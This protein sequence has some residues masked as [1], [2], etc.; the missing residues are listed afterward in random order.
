[1]SAVFLD[2]SGWLSAL[3]PREA[4]HAAA[5]GAYRG[6]IQRGERLET[7]NLVL[8]EMQILVSR[9][10][11]AGEALRFLDAVYADPSHEV[12]HVTRELERAAIDRWLRRFADQR[13]SLADAT[14]FEV[15][16]E[17]RIQRVLTLDAH[18]ALA[19]FHAVP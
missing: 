4:Q 17:Q 6:G 2:T 1:V 3:S 11:D 8:A 7:T 15:M 12:V 5:L 9:A 19:G 16:R 18:F 10:R 13:I 14:S